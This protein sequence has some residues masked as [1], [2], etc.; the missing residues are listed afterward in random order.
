MEVSRSS[1]HT[2]REKVNK[3]DFLSLHRTGV[4]ITFHPEEKFKTTSGGILS[5]KTENVSFVQKVRRVARPFSSRSS[6][7]LITF[8]FVLH[9]RQVT[10]E[11]TRP[12]P[13]KMLIQSR[14]PISEDQKIV[15]KLVHPSSSL[16]AQDADGQGGV[17]RWV[18]GK[19]EE[20]TIEWSGKVGGREKKVWKYGWEVEGNGW[21]ARPH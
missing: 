11:N 10:V 6:S 19:R 8:L 1:S 15:V 18:E 13:I 12:Q 3:A 9:L 5:S 17:T 14:F 2:R 20:G 7:P 21:V 16:P 4:R